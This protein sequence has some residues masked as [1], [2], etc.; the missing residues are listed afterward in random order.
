M[1]HLI[2]REDRVRADAIALVRCGLR[3][4]VVR[5]LIG[6][7]ISIQDCIYLFKILTPLAPN[8]RHGRVK[9]NIV[10]GSTERKLKPSAFRRLTGANTSFCISALNMVS[11]AIELGASRADALASVW[12]IETDKRSLPLHHALEGITA[13]DLGFIWLNVNAQE[14]AVRSCGGCSNKFL[15]SVPSLN[16]CPFCKVGRRVLSRK[17]A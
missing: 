15:D 8:E 17:A 1:R 13:E 6:N 16:S 10:G 2:E 7:D 3:P 9:F 11:Q 14:I 4:K 5:L 12:R